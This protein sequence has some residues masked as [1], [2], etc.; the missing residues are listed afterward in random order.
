[1]RVDTLIQSSGG[2]TSTTS[3]GDPIAPP[4]ISALTARVEDMYKQVIEYTSQLDKPIKG[5]SQVRDH[6]RWIED[7][8]FRLFNPDS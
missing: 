3:Y 8:E 5:V 2:I 6:I 7:H 1:M 4:K